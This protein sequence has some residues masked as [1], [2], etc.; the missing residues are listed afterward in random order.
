MVEM[1]SREESGSVSMA[2]A[3]PMPS[4]EDYVQ[5]KSQNRALKKAIE[6]LKVCLSFNFLIA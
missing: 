3:M 1:E 2:Y 4:F 5:I 6:D